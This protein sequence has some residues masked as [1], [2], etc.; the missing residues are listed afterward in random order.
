MTFS[1]TRRLGTI[2][3]DVAVRWRGTIVIAIPVTCLLTSLVAFGLLQR[4]TLEVRENIEKTQQTLYISDLLLT[5]LLD[6]E[7][8]VRG[9]IIAQS[10]DYLKP[11]QSAIDGIPD[12]LS[13]L[14]ELVG[15]KPQ[16]QARVQRLQQLI[17]QK[18]QI[19][20]NHV[21]LPQ[22]QQ[23][24]LQRRA[25]LDK[26]QSTMNAIRSTF[27]ELESE[28]T[29]LLREQNQDWQRHQKTTNI[30]LWLAG[31]IGV[32]GAF[33]SFYLFDRLDQTL[34]KRAI[35]LREINLRI[36]AI[37][38][39]VVDG[40]MTVNEKGHIESFNQAAQEMFGYES[41]E[42][43]D[44]NLKQLIGVPINSNS[45]E[46]LKEFIGIQGKKLRQQQ[47]VLGKRKNGTTFPMELAF[48]EMR[49]HARHLYIGILRDISDRKE[50]ED[51]LGKQAQLLDLA[52]D[53]ILVCDRHQ[54]ITFWNQGAERLYG[55]SKAEAMGCNVNILLKTEFSQPLEE[56]EKLFLEQGYWTGEILNTQ[57]DGTQI[58]VA[59]RWTLQVDSNGEPV[60]TLEIN[61]DIS[62]RK[63]AEASLVNRAKELAQLTSILAQTNSA[64]EKRNQELDRFAYVVSHDL[65]APL[66]AINNLSEW[67]E[68]DIKDALTPDTHHQMELLRGRVH[69]ME[70]LIN[71]LLEYS[72]AGRIQ[73]NIK[74]VNVAELLTEIIDSLAPS[75]E[76]TVIIEPGMPTFL[77]EPLPLE[78]VFANLISNAIKHH[79]R[80]DGKVT[81]SVVDKGRVYEFAVTDDGPGIAVEYHDKIFGIFETLQ[82]KDRGDST[83][84]GLAIVKRIIEDKGGTIRLVSQLGRG[85]TFYFTWLKQTNWES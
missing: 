69:R 32:A 42:I 27:K 52:N 49:L 80:T 26:G 21:A 71:G 33:A 82:S 62:E 39:N 43:I 37:L 1:K 45:Q 22:T 54:K 12:S 83:G 40:I 48:S 36:Q 35:R 19:L 29:E 53:A 81:L 51:T 3:A 66:R 6:A 85:T 4:S 76:F 20:Q 46:L 50:A 74:S 67:I 73:D 38:D 11:Y 14:N 65:K 31:V 60:A 24:L 23:Q 15:E 57:R 41:S 72:R 55:Y 56:I 70:A 68:E 78:Q 28:E 63:L 58:A 61:N 34:A 7:T 77:T 30:V 2:W 8:S 79:D 17:P 84:I 44:K 10:S 18:V 25:L 47:E 59:S 5:R 16:Q 13:K 64:L 9:Y 75:P